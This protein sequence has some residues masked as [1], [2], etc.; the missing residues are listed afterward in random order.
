MKKLIILLLII[1]ALVAL[2]FLLLWTL[3]KHLGFKLLAAEIILTGISGSLLIMSCGLMVWRRTWQSLLDHKLPSTDIIN[4]LVIYAAGIALA[5]PGAAS[6][7][8]AVALLLKFWLK[9]DCM[10]L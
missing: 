3:S 6:D 9:M 8:L 4:G 2:D 1:A 7:A 10:F 5:I